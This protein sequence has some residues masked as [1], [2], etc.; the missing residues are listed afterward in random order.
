MVAAV[1]VGTVLIGAIAHVGRQMV[2]VHR[3]QSVADVAA[4]AGAVGGRADVARTAA[5]NGATVVAV[6][7]RPDGGV[8]VT[9][10]LGGAVASAAALAG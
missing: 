2:L 7:D 10:G 4:L 9:I 1:L 5:A 3:A 8:D 6:V